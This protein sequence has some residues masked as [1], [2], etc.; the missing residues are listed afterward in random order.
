MVRSTAALLVLLT[1]STADADCASSA[2]CVSSIT[3]TRTNSFAVDGSYVYW[4]AANTVYATP[5]QGGASRIIAS[6]EAAP[7]VDA[8]DAPYVYWHTSTLVRR[9]PISGVGP[10]ET[11]LTSNRIR[12]VVLR[13]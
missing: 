11:L 10:T 9:A 12:Q 4:A 1:A 2:P 6:G 8:I 3:N 7:D 13:G 5:K